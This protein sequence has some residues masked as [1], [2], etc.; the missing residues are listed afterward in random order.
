MRHRCLH[1]R[2]PAPRFRLACSGYSS[3]AKERLIKSVYEPTIGWFDET[4]GF[5]EVG[6]AKRA[7]DAGMLI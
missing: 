2:C 6:G 1:N 5:L 3:C 7:P 4:Q